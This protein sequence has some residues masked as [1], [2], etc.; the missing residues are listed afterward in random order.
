[1]AHL[2]SCGG[3]KLHQKRVQTIVK[4]YIF[5][6]TYVVK[7]DVNFAMICRVLIHVEHSP[8]MGHQDVNDPNI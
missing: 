2:A 4:Q 3:K 7:E 5:A 1:M 6:E 8:L